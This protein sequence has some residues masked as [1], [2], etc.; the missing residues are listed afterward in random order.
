MGHSLGGLIIRAA[1]P[2][3]KAYK[4]RMFTYMSFGTPHL[5]CSN[6]NSTLVKTG[7]KF[8]SKVMGHKSLNEISLSDASDLKDC[9]LM[10][11]SAAEVL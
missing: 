6:N 5:G 4:D 1:L 2:K 3:L 10:K 7:L 8:F 11:L 9:Y